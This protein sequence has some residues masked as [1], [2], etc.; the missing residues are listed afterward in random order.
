MSN[1]YLNVNGTFKKLQ[2]WYVKSPPSAPVL[3]FD[4][5]NDPLDYD[6]AFKTHIINNLGI[7]TFDFTNPP[8]GSSILLPSFTLGNKFDLEFRYKADAQNDANGLSCIFTTQHDR[9]GVFGDSVF[10]IYP[11]LSSAGQPADTL[12]IHFAPLD[13]PSGHRKIILTDATTV[14]QTTVFGGQRRLF[15]GLYDGNWHTFRFSY[16]QGAIS[17]TMDNDDGN[18]VAVPFYSNANDT[19]TVKTSVLHGSG[20]GASSFGRLMG[21]YSY[22]DDKINTNGFTSHR[23]TT[24]R[25]N[26]HAGSLDFFKLTTYPSGVQTT[27]IDYPIKDG[28]AS[29]SY[30]PIVDVSGNNNDGQHIY[31]SN[32]TLSNQWDYT[33]GSTDGWRKV[34][35]AYYN[36]SGVWKK[37]YEEK[38]VLNIETTTADFDLYV[39]AGSP[40]IDVEVILYIASGVNVYSTTTSHGAIYGSSN[41]SAGSTIKIVNNGTVWGKG[42]DGGDCPYAT[43]TITAK[44]VNSKNNEYGSVRKT[45]S[46]GGSSSDVQA[47]EDGGDAITL[48]GNTTIDNTFGRLF[49]CGGGGGATRIYNYSYAGKTGKS[50]KTPYWNDASVAGGG[51]AGYIGGTGGQ[52]T[53]SVV[54]WDWSIPSSSINSFGTKWGSGDATTVKANDGSRTTG[55]K[56]LIGHHNE[57]R[58]EETDY[59]GKGGNLG[60]GGQNKNK[61]HR[62]TEGRG[63]D[64]KIVAN[65]GGRGYAINKNNQTL[66]FIGD[67][68][69]TDVFKGGILDPSNPPSDDDGSGS[70]HYIAS[71]TNRSD[72]SGESWLSKTC[73][74]GTACFYQDLITSDELMGM[75]RWRI[76]K[77][78]KEFLADAKWLGYQIGFR[79][80]SKAMMRNKKIAILVYEH[81]VKDW[82]KKTQEKRH[83]KVKIALAQSYCVLVY[84]FKYKK[85]LELNKKISKNPK[86][87]LN[88]YKEMIN[89]KNLLR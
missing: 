64:L 54:G 24:P 52:L 38:I 74:L 7:D 18:F 85:C 47:G 57:Q 16:D 42:G 40:S 77:Q 9:Q 5:S 15:R 51:G 70:E 49:G 25:Y 14:S 46:A 11:L 30:Q 50:T 55:A 36:D 10:A 2:E 33:A 67:Q 27:L 41:F 21:S 60:E 71:D 19:S 87:I 73:V 53:K 63:S 23:E 69:N 68:N 12:A 3:K 81:F 1:A 45:L 61:G 20:Y 26:A 72:S 29:G 32:I 35:E 78:S 80:L 8:Q 31:A 6:E 86:K 43:G 79:P 62:K 44:Y 75:I 39:Q 28:V 4:G 84:I 37:F 48:C 13:D 89:N 65:N 17:A 83:S 82:I 22:W 59:Y 88:S 34:V 56:S 66:T 58:L 76:R